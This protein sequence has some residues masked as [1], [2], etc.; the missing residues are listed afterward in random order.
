MKDKKTLDKIQL[1]MRES[2]LN[3][4]TKVSLRQSGLAWDRTGFLPKIWS[5]EPHSRP[6]NSGNGFPNSAFL[7]KAQ[8]ILMHAKVWEPLI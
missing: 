1:S 7:T 3:I 8:I 6:L 2:Y 5:P 4:K